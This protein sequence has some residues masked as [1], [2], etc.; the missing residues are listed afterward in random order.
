[1]GGI[2]SQKLQEGGGSKILGKKEMVSKKGIGVILEG[3][4]G[5]DQSQ[6]VKF[7]KQ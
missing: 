2:D 3:R 4:G 7:L 1:M 6:K 5:G